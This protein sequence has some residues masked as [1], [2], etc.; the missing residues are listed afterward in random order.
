MPSRREVLSIALLESLA[1]GRPIV[2]MKI[3][4][5]E[6]VFDQG[7]EG[8]FVDME[9]DR[10]L[11]DMLSLLLSDRALRLKMGRAARRRAHAFDINVV[12]GQLKNA[13]RELS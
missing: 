13:V 4:G 6:E 1:A 9:D 2:C 10:Q 5:L 3:P 7:V 11:A 12:G 8:Y